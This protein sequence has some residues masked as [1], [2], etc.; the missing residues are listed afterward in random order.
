MENDLGFDIL[1]L[2]VP[3]WHHR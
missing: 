2:L 3:L 1:A